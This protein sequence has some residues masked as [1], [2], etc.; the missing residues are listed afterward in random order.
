MF[1]PLRTQGTDTEE[2]GEGVGGRRDA[3]AQTERKSGWKK[4][5]HLFTDCRPKVH[6]RT[7][8]QNQKM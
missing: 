3:A 5:G 4:R 7:I 2:S 8:C 1:W 6:P